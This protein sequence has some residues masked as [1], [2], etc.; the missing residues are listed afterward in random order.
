MNPAHATTAGHNRSAPG[1]FKQ[2]PY[3]ARTMAAV[4]V[5]GRRATR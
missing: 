3:Q 5:P 4:A 1:D 2:K